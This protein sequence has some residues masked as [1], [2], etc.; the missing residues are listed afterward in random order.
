MRLFPHENGVNVDTRL[1]NLIARC[2]PQASVW[3]QD[4]LK[5]I[6]LLA[7]VSEEVAA[8]QVLREIS[9][10]VRRQD[11]AASDFGQ[12]DHARGLDTSEHR[13]GV[14]LSLYSAMRH[15]CT[16]SQSSMNDGCFNPTR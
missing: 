10:C 6:E 1:L 8:R 16:P 14:L 12:P 11:F 9:D 5:Q 15:I 4:V 7:P 2:P 3:A 13:L